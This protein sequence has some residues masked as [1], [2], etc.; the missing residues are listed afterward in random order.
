M[1]RDYL[2]MYLN[3]A[4]S[5]G[6]RN[7]IAIRHF[8]A[9]TARLADAI[10]NGNL[11]TDLN[12]L[13]EEAR[14]VEHFKQVTVLL[15]ST[16]SGRKNILPAAA[17]SNLRRIYSKLQAAFYAV[18]PSSMKG[19]IFDFNIRSGIRNIDLPRPYTD[20]FAGSG[21][22]KSGWFDMQPNGDVVFELHPPAIIDGHGFVAVTFRGWD[23]ILL[24]SM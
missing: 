15:D 19:R 7:P 11:F 17:Q 13:K 12:A 16:L 1:A 9:D 6:D 23:R 3:V 22:F 4:F 14:R 20:G 2:A 18:N 10:R 5:F 24:T 21:T 8:S